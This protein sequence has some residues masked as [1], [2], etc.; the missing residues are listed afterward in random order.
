MD[1]HDNGYDRVRGHDRVC[2]HAGARGRAHDRGFQQLVPAA[3]PGAALL[4]AA[5]PG[6]M[7]R[8]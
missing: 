3:Q 7:K 8:P 5:L 4:A 6:R 1:D 2:D